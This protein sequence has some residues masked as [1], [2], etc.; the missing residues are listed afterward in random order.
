MKD[1]M[2]EYTSQK[3]SC[4]IYCENLVIVIWEQKNSIKRFIYIIGLYLIF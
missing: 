2:Q 3:N 4:Y 1:F